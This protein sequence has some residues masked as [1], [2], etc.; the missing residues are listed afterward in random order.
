MKL[1]HSLNVVELK[2]YGTQRQLAETT[3]L[4]VGSVCIDN[5]IV[6]GKSPSLI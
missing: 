6:Q 1:L 3:Y 5:Y 2:G 4:R